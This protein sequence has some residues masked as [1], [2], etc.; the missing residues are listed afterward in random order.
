MRPQR[1]GRPHGTGRVRF[2]TAGRE[3]SATAAARCSPSSPAYVAYW[4]LADNRTAP[5]FVRYWSNSGQRYVLALE[6]LSANDPT[7]ARDNKCSIAPLTS[8]S[9]VAQPVSKTPAASRTITET[10]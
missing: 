5:E 1:Q 10:T 3:V 4:H 7:R 9:Y 6:G 2:Y 8:A